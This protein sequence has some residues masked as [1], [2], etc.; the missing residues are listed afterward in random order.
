[1]WGETVVC[2]ALGTVQDWGLKMSLKKKNKGEEV[3]K[4]RKKEEKS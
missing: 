2:A 4:K 3:K 1:M